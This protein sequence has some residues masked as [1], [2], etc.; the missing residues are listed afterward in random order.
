MRL[1]GRGLMAENESH[2]EALSNVE[3]GKA[4]I[5]SDEQ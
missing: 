3:A 2:E 1:P 4:A 5:L